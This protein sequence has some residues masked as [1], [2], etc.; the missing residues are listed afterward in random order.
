MQQTSP[1]PLP[2]L[3]AT[4]ESSPARN[5]LN[6]LARIL[7]TDRHLAP[8]VAR[9]A[10]GLVVLPHGV[11]KTLG[12]FGGYGFRGTMQWFTDTMHIPWIFGFAAILAETVGAVALLLGLASRVAAASLAIVFVTAAALVHWPHGFFANWFGNQAGEGYEYFILGLALALIV[13][14]HGGGAA[15]IDRRLTAHAGSTSPSPLDAPAT[16]AR[17]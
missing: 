4:P 6:A 17:G 9:I 2:L 3:R 1:T 12:W 11:Q 10:L 14:V 13:V 15:S 8:A 7:V 5:T 16:T